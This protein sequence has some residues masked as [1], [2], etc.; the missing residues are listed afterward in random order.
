MM[1]SAVCASRTYDTI[2]WFK[3]ITIPCNCQ[4]LLRICHYHDSLQTSHDHISNVCFHCIFNVA[5]NALP[6]I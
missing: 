3:D 6:Y 4:A 5:L 2:M 1:H